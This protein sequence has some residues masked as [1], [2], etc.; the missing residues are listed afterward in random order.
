MNN[1]INVPKDFSEK[2]KKYSID[3]GIEALTLTKEKLETIGLSKE[4]IMKYEK[5]SKEKLAAVSS[6]PVDF[7]EWRAA[8]RQLCDYWIT[9]V[10]LNSNFGLI[11]ARFFSEKH[12]PI[13]DKVNDPIDGTSLPVF[14]LTWIISPTYPFFQMSKNF[15]SN[16]T[17]IDEILY[18]ILAL[19]CLD[20]LFKFLILFD[21]NSRLKSL[22]S[23]LYH[24]LA[25]A[26]YA[27][28]SY[29]VMYFI[30]PDWLSD[31]IFYLYIYVIIPLELFIA[32]YATVVLL[33]GT[34]LYASLMAM[35]IALLASE[36]KNN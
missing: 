18:W 2:L 11:W 19:K 12:S 33:L 29:H 5:V 6:N 9:P 21:S 8:H 3:T 15:K 23:R 34:A 7:F 16:S 36:K 20:D 26:T 32:F 13:I 17:Y 35:A 25:S 1:K 4:N 22:S 28:F 24:L 30:I 10:L 14:F 31:A 27:L